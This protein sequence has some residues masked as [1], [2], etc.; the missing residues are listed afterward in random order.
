MILSLQRYTKSI[1]KK[2]EN[3]LLIGKE[4][5]MKELGTSQEEQDDLVSLTFE[6]FRNLQVGDIVYFVD[7]WD[8]F[9]KVPFV[10]DYAKWLSSGEGVYTSKGKS[11]YYLQISFVREH[12]K[13]Y[14]DSAS[15]NYR[16][17]YVRSLLFAELLNREK[18]RKGR[19]RK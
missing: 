1:S 3:M 10:I 12:H 8:Y 5:F 16:N 2:G 7:D 17:L 19:K 6:T 15:R 18:Q 4:E 13:R 9:I 14:A 11:F